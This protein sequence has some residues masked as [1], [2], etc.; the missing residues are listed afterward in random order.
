M[1]IVATAGC[2]LP[3]AEYRDELNTQ[4]VWIIGPT[5][6]MVAPY[7]GIWCVGIAS[8]LAPC[9]ADCRAAQV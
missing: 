9:A 2:P 3:S 8:A 6:A 7:H 4:R 5:R 1:L